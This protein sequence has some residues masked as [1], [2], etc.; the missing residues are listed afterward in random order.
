MG[1]TI[2]IDL[3]GLQA[4]MAKLGDRA[5]EAARPAAQAAA[6]VLYDA[7]KRNVKTMLGTKTGNLYNS[8][9]QAYSKDNSAPGHA[10]YHV[11]WNDKKA[12][13]GHWFEYGYKVRYEYYQD[14]QGRVRP[15]VRPE[16]MGK[17]RP[18]SNGS[19]RAALDA[20]YVTLPAPKQVPARPF[21]RRAQ[22]A[23]ADAQK[24]AEAALL[25]YIVKGVKP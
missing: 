13:H 14:E 21:V 9:Y 4:Q 20:Y 7:V 10:V 19:N 16:M 8:I 12:P 23:T 17:P 2:N 6:Q 15:R 25:S 24:A 5:E 22:S 1:M 3:Q 11:S 18:K